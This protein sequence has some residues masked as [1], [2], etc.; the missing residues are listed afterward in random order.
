MSTHHLWMSLCGVAE[1]N[2]IFSIQ[3]RPLSLSQ[4]S[5]P[6]PF[7]SAA[8]LRGERLYR[9]TTMSLY[10]LNISFSMIHIV[11]STLSSLSSLDDCC[12]MILLKV[13]WGDLWNNKHIFCF[14]WS[15]CSSIHQCS[16][17][18]GQHLTCYFCQ[19]NSLIMSH[20]RTDGQRIHPQERLRS[21]TLQFL[22]TIWCCGV[23]PFACLHQLF[24]QF[25][26]YLTI[27]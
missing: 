13:L 1:Q 3:R 2:R 10:K 21:K 15:C 24:L 9:Q 4:V 25:I 23:L 27:H 7:T 17:P 26:P 20:M 6:Q 18:S 16:H 8:A 14:D 19:I 12:C 5:N 11:L 22:S